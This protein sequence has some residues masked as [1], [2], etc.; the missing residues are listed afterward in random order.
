MNSQFQKQFDWQQKYYDFVIKILRALSPLMIDFAVAS[1]YQDMKQS[2]DFVLQMNNRTNIAVRLRK[3]PCNFR[4]LTIRS[5]SYYG[6][7]TELTKLKSGFADWYFYGWANQQGDISEFM[8]LDIDAI[9]NANL[10]DGN[11]TIIN[12]DNRTGFIS[13]SLPDLRDAKAIIA[14]KVVYDGTWI[15]YPKSWEAWFKRYT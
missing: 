1:D 2:T 6:G 5:R 11:Q 12:K 15:Y 9:R 8:L 3:Y 14:I 4:D 13:I 10:L 7:A